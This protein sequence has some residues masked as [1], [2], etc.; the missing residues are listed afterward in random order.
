MFKL[1][2][3]SNAIT[4]VAPFSLESFDQMWHLVMTSWVLVSNIPKYVKLAK[5]TMVQ[6]IGSMEV[7][8]C[9][10]ILTFMKSKFRNRFITHLPF[11]VHMFAQQLY[12]L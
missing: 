9:S 5:L 12:T 2:M 1:I 11:V 3:K 6:I 8:R 4:C 10:S 7:E